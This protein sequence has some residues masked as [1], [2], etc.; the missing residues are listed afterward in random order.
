MC[1]HVIVHTPWCVCVFECMHITL[2][3]SAKH[4]MKFEVFIMTEHNKS[5]FVLPGY[6]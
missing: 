6:L 5:H 2:S 4:F 1:V 3:V